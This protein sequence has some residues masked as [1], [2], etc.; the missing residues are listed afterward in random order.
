MRS[1]V[2]NLYNKVGLT[3]FQ[4]AMGNYLCRIPVY[5][6]CRFLNSIRTIETAS[7]LFR[8]LLYWINV[9]C[10]HVHFLAV[11]RYALRIWHVDTDRPCMI[12]QN[13][14]EYI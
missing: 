1:L 14:P 13:T 4:S 11:Q 3:R 9:S 8:V 6:I 12:R 5:A 7:H 2:G 10:I